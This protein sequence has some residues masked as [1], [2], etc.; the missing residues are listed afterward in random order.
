MINK[1]DDHW[2]LDILAAEDTRFCP[3]LCEKPSLLSLFEKKKSFNSHFTRKR[4]TKMVQ[5]PDTASR[6]LRNVFITAR[7]KHV[8]LGAV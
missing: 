6:S 3:L 2:S 5:F 8:V 4:S 7:D 1:S